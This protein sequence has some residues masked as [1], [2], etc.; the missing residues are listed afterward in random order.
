VRTVFGA[1]KDKIS[2]L[3]KDFIRL[4]LSKNQFVETN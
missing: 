2:H 4:I 1:Q 3:L